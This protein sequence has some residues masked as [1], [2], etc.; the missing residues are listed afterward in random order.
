MSTHVFTS[1]VGLIE[2]AFMNLLENAV[3]YSS[4][5]AEITVSVETTDDYDVYFFQQTRE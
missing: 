5:R 3:K 2:L 4:N 1:I